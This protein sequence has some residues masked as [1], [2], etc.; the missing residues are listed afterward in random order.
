M[1]LIVKRQRI[2]INLV[3][4]ESIYD[5]VMSQGLLGVYL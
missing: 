5:G 3:D 1:S 4:F 2:F